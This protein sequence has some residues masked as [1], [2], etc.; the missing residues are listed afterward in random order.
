MVPRR[1][2][3]RCGAGPGRRHGRARSRAGFA[4]H[5]VRQ[6]DATPRG[7]HPIRTTR[8]QRIRSSWLRGSPC[9][10]AAGQAAPGAAGQGAPGAA[11]ATTTGRPAGAGGPAARSRRR[12]SRS[13]KKI[14]SASISELHARHVFRP[15]R[16]LPRASSAYAGG[17]AGTGPTRIPA[18]TGRSG[19]TDPRRA[20]RSPASPPAPRRAPGERRGWFAQTW[21]RSV[22][23]VCF[24][25]SIAWVGTGGEPFFGI[26]RRQ[27][28]RGGGQQQD[29]ERD[30]EQREPQGKRLGEPG[31][32]GGKEEPEGIEDEQRSRDPEAG[33]D[34]ERRGLLLALELRELQVQLHERLHSCL[35]AFGLSDDLEHVEPPVSR[36]V[37]DR[38]T[39][40]VTRILPAA[41]A[42]ETNA[43]R[44]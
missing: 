32:R 13:F 42:G 39:A 26:A 38:W 12:M 18:A 6:Y 22:V 2:R 17:R 8:A 10:N 30:D 35:D 14:F 40:A 7:H 15:F 9:R 33:R 34:A 28:T 41:Q 43:V 23:T 44:V 19:R 31:R 16:P 36:A 24:V 27:P 37:P 25:S 20:S 11:A 21:L 29:H 3:L 5:A 1:A 4:N